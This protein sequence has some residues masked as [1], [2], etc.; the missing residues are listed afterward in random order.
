MNVKYKYRLSIEIENKLH[1][2][3]I[4]AESKDQAISLYYTYFKLDKTNMLFADF[5]RLVICEQL[6]LDNIEQF[7]GSEA[8]FEKMCRYRKIEFAYLGMRV[9]IAGRMATIIGN[10]KSDLAVIYDNIP[11]V[12][13]ADPRWEVVYFDKNGK[14]IKKRRNLEGVLA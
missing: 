9:Q 2:M 4:G 14:V 1:A 5:K 11:K 12:F 7:F 6:G 13:A 10:N 3:E 8:E